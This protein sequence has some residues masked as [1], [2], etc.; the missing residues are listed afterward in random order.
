[1]KVIMNFSGKKFISL[2]QVVLCIDFGG[3]LNPTPVASTQRAVTLRQHRSSMHLAQRLRTASDLLQIL[4][5]DTT[6]Y[7][8]QIQHNHSLK[9][10]CTELHFKHNSK[11]IAIHQSQAEL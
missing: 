4:T 3:A 9:P 7:A 6:Y 10:C 2:N 1:M 5:E 8:L 11:L